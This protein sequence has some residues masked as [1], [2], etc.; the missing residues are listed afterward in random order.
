MSV[1]KFQPTPFLRVR[2]LSAESARTF[3]GLPDA[4]VKLAGWGKRHNAPVY[5][6]WTAPYPPPEGEGWEAPPL[7]P[8]GEDP[9]GQS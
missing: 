1:T 5:W 6:V 2:A 8:N 3:F 9:K 7:V 4:H